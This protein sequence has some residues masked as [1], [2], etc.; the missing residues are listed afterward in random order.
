M[1]DITELSTNEIDDIDG[2]LMFSV[3]PGWGVV[4]GWGGAL[5]AVATGA[6]PIAGLIGGAI[7]G[8][9]ILVGS[10]NT[11]GYTGNI[12]EWNAP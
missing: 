10:G 2:G 9:A 6:N 12:A 5:G 7:I 8:Y 1:N 3:G 11:Q 4:A